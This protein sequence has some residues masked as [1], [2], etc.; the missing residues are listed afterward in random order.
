MTLRH[1]LLS[2]IWCLVIYWRYNDE[3]IKFPATEHY[4]NYKIVATIFKIIKNQEQL[5][6]AQILFKYFL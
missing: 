3:I 1:F 2:L 4:V 6:V 5:A